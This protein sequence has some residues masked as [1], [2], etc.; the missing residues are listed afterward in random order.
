MDLFGCD[1]KCRTVGECIAKYK[2]PNDWCAEFDI[3]DTAYP[4]ICIQVGQIRRT[5][6]MMDMELR[7]VENKDTEYAGCMILAEQ[8][9]VAFKIDFMSDFVKAM[10]TME[11]E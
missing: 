5:P 3:Y 1:Y 9:T 11:L 2:I 6:A 10:N 4:I 7:I 8:R